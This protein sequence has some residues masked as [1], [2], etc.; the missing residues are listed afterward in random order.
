M[1]H[2]SWES[3]FRSRHIFAS[4]S[5]PISFFRSFRVVNSSP[6]YNRP[7]LPLPLSATNSQGELPSPGQTL[8]TPLEFGTLH[9]SSIGQICPSVKCDRQAGQTDLP[10]S[11]GRQI[12][13]G[14]SSP[15]ADSCVA[16]HDALFCGLMPNARMADCDHA[17]AARPFFPTSDSSLSEAP[18]GF[19]SP[20]SHLL[21]KL[22]VTLR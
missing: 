11:L 6:K 13:F 8:H 7:W 21:T 17:A 12:R 14:G 1:R 5:R 4:R 20:R 3:I 15:T 16:G 10:A 18:E 22:V 2:K 9:T 19:F